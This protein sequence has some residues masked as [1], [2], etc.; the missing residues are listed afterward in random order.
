MK[1]NKRI[2][3]GQQVEPY[4]LEHKGIRYN[5]SESII[6][7][8]LNMTNGDTETDLFEYCLSHMPREFITLYGDGR[9]NMICFY[10]VFPNLERIE[11]MEE[12]KTEL[13]L[14][15]NDYFTAAPTD[16]TN[17]QGKIIRIMSQT[18]H[19]GY[20]IPSRNIYLL[21]DFTH[22]LKSAQK[23]CKNILPI[24]KDIAKK[25]GVNSG[26]K[27]DCKITFGADPEFCFWKSNSM[28]SAEPVIK[29]RYYKGRSIS[30][31]DSEIEI[32]TDGHSSTGELRPIQ[33]TSGEELHKNIHDLLKKIYNDFPDYN[34]DCIGNKLALGFHIHFGN[35]YLAEEN[36]NNFVYVL[37][38]YLGNI[39]LPLSGVARG[40][41]S[42]LHARENKR[43]GFEYR[44]LPAIIMHD[45]EILRI[46]LKLCENLAK[47]FIADEKEFKLKKRA[48]KKIEYMEFITS[49]EYQTIFKFIIDHISIFERERQEGKLFDN[50]FEK[51]K[52][53][54]KIMFNDDFF[55]D[56]MRH[57][58]MM[59]KITE[60]K[61]LF[62]F[63]LKSSRG[64][65]AVMTNLKTPVVL[66]NEAFTAL[67][68]CPFTIKPKRNKLMIGLSMAMRDGSYYS[69]ELMNCVLDSVYNAFKLA[70][71]N[72]GFIF[73]QNLPVESESEEDEYFIDD[74]CFNDNEE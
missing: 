73:E 58:I 33:A 50:W 74:L 43:Y 48:P 69:D 61:N 56:Q 65:G 7:V 19:I 66:N 23:F 49:K 53:L 71:N 4:L 39:L 42:K 72:D 62:F 24:L 30:L 67:V 27:D 5:N 35:I 18:T 26:L 68:S 8:V 60:F 1:I 20:Y 32:G 59:H 70:I 38:Y 15:D 40:S 22:N 16:Y 64:K 41:Y 28:V 54:P 34:I 6:D 17:I 31:T 52:C 63:G 9:C 21:R 47:A 12:I 3:I 36:V 44:S 29:D 13:S 51:R 2:F 55:R 14:S 37:D 45:P 10:C 11:D 57:V 46:V 25:V